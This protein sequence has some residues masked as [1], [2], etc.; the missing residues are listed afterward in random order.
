VHVNLIGGHGILVTQTDVPILTIFLDTVAAGGVVEPLTKVT[1]PLTPLGFIKPRRRSKGLPTSAILP[2]TGVDASSGAISLKWRGVTVEI[3]ASH[4]SS[5]YPIY[6]E[7]ARESAIVLEGE[8]RT[9]LDLSHV[10]ADPYDEGDMVEELGLDLTKLGSVGT[11][12]LA[13]GWLMSN[14]MTKAIKAVQ[15][16]KNGNGNGSMSAATA[17]LEKIANKDDQMIELLKR[18]TDLLD[19]S[20]SLLRDNDKHNVR[21]EEH[22][23]RTEEWQRRLEQ[24]TE[25]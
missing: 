5:P 3:A 6:Y 14:M 15:V 7:E 10:P 17:G 9:I 8:S 18:Q 24:S 22:R 13:L 12:V 19:Q 25:T 16:R 2:V 4:D 1:V 11:F 20:V 23:R 21:E